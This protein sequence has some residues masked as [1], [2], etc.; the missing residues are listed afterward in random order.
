VLNRR[1]LRVVRR[2]IPRFLQDQI[3]P[4][5]RFM[6]DAVQRFIAGLP[7]G[8]LVLDAG[9][10]ETQYKKLF[11]R[12]GH[13]YRAIDLGV[14][15]TDWQY[16]GIDALADTAAIPFRPGIFDGVM[17]IAVLE[18]SPRPRRVL[19]ELN[20]ALKPGGRLLIVVPTMW[21]EHQ[22]PH[23]FYRFT[24]FGLE[25]LLEEAGFGVLERYPIGGYFWFMGRK[26]IDIL[27]FFQRFPQALLWPLLAPVFGF[28]IPVVCRQL[29]W[30]D[31]DK[32]YTIG[33]VCFA[34]KVRA[35]EGQPLTQS[36]P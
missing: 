22:V 27:E 34:E 28:L 29:D 20:L 21:E 18:H 17:S 23:D 25:R 24:R 5:D 33:Q 26:S 36:L 2:L 7:A 35:A 3:N 10:G 15:E 19:C 8:S 11:E 1:L 31:R 6:L 32:Y 13:G 16:S 12:A 30:L 9:A 4:F 14:G